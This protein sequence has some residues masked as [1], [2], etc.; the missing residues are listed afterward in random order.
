MLKL[1]RSGDEGEKV[2]LLVESGARLHTIEV[3]ASKVGC[4]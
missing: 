2:L 1:S 3:R 4:C